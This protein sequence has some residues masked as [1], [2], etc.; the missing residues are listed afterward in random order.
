MFDLQ[1]PDPGIEVSIA[2]SGMFKAIAQSEGPQLVVKPFVK[3]GD[4]RLGRQWKN[5]TSGAANGEGAIF[6]GISREVAKFQLSLQASY[7]FQTGVKGADH[8]LKAEWIDVMRF[9]RMT[10]SMTN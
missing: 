4:L 2:S 9:T 1:P 5:V 3:L 6:A 7:K 8:R 10:A